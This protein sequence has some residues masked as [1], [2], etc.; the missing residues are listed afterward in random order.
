MALKP[1]KR[2]A[3]NFYRSYFDVLNELEKDEDKLSFLTAVINKQFL[4]EN[5]K[6]LNFIVKLSYESQRHSIEASVKGYKDKTKTDLLGNP[7]VGAKKDPWQGGSKGGKQAPSAQEKEQDVNINT[8]NLYLS[9]IDRN[10]LQDI[11][12]FTDVKHQIYAKIAKYFH[13]EFELKRKTKTLKEAKL[14]N[15]V[16]TVRLIIEVDKRDKFELGMILE[17]FALC[18]AGECK[19]N[20]WFTTI[21]SIAAL[22]NKTK[23]GDYYFD[24]IITQIEKIAKKN[25]LFERKVYDFGR[26]LKNQFNG[27]N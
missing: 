7:L 21:N 11:S 20:F 18:N 19:D 22:R 26:K 13:T 24:A 17:Y 16:N 8:S 4:D 23:S 2:K 10:Y 15:W 3:F 25:E 6:D 12:N 14:D 1:T 27:I 9:D 5:P